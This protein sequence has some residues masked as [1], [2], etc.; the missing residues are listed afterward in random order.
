MIYRAIAYVLRSIEDESIVYIDAATRA[1]AHEAL[2]AV[3]PT[4]WGVEPHRVEYYNLDD[5][6]DLV[7]QAFGDAHTGD[8]RLLEIGWSD[9]RPL[10]ASADRTLLLLGPRSLRRMVQ[11]QQLAAQLPRTEFAVAA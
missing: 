8:A 7:S 1:T 4:I 9:N 5:E 11:A 3:L 2:S 6:H 10:Y